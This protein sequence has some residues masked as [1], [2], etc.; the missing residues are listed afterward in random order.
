MKN[1]IKV[2][3]ATLVI[4]SS[5]LFGVPAVASQTDDLFNNINNEIEPRTDIKEWVFKVE[6]EIV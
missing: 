4:S 5:M 2:L 1:R 3:I 6:T